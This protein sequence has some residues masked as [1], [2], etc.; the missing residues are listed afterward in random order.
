MALAVLKLRLGLAEPARRVW[1]H[2][3]PNRSTLDE[4]PLERAADCPACAAA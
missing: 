4:K 2:F 1:L 3:D